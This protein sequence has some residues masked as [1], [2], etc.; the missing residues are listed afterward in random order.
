MTRAD[1]VDTALI[2][3]FLAWLTDEK[4]LARSSVARKA[5][6][7]RAFFRDLAR[8][9]TVAKS[10]A[11]Y[12]MA[13]R[14]GRPLPHYLTE[15][16]MTAL[17]NAPDA[18]RPDGLRDRAIL[19]T[20]YASGVRVGELVAL[21]QADITLSGD[22][23]GTLHI[24]RGKGGKERFA[25]LG[26]AAVSALARYQESGRPFLARV[27]KRPTDALFLNRFGGRLTDRSVRRM[28][29]KYCAD[30]AASQKVTPHTLR[31]TFATH[32]LDHGGGPPGGSGIAWSRRPIQHPDLHARLARS[33]QSGLRGR[34]SP[35]PTRLFPRFR[36]PSLTFFTFRRYC[37][38]FCLS[39]R[40]YRVE[41]D[42]A[43]PFCR[44]R[45]EFIGETQARFASYNTWF[46]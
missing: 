19:E 10:P 31:H 4:G 12:V 43:L 33:P 37:R 23:E 32:L 21:N 28:F 1:A 7:V 42:A 29:D 13:P 17:L 14:K 27:A 35:C 20:L 2:R 30:V 8:R 24:R 36:K 44:A 39:Q 26:G 3:A 16:S 41:S 40:H 22:R 5:S 34:A 15:D 46:P 9:G 45:I 38:G 6:S 18:A 11:H 25:L